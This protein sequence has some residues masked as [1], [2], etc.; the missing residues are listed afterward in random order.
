M[1]TISV[2]RTYNVGQYQSLKVWTNIDN[3][4]ISDIDDVLT[5]VKYLT[6]LLDVAYFNYISTSPV[7][8]NSLTKDVIEQ[9]KEALSKL[10]PKIHIEQKE[11]K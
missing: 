3:I 5:A 10:K 6:I 7:V 1:S 8:N 2:E 9:Y 4:D 11:E